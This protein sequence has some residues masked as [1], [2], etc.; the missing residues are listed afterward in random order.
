MTRL[1]IT[2]ILPLAVLVHG[3][4]SAQAPETVK[5]GSFT[6]PGVATVVSVDPG[7][8][9]CYVTLKDARGQQSTEPAAFELC[10]RQPSPLVGKRVQLQYTLSQV[11]ADA[12][13]GDPSC[14]KKQTVALITSATVLAGAA[15]PAATPAA[16]ATPPGQAS[17]CT[18]QETVVFACRAGSKMVS[19]C[20][21]K[22]AGR[23]RG[24]L[25]YRFGKPDSREPLE[26][27]LPEAP[28]P[29]ARAA[30]GENVP[31]AGGGGSW[32]RFS[33][34]D[35]AY[36]VYSGIGRWGPKGETITKQG[37]VVERGGKAIANV[38]C[39]DEPA[40]ELG[41]E[42]FEKMGVV[43]GKQDFLFP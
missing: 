30:A 17:F 23:G 6:K 4:A 7:D 22:D 32:L 38:K 20:A 18:P 37:V 36:V 19:V 14:K 8:A 24:M 39:S 16:A 43:V 40:G 31:F 34:G 25:Q 3:L 33:K 41:P 5:V 21:S 15:A 29:P 1:P 27:I 10:T 2:R 35:T 28:V 11:A 13:G 9:A 42:W 26:M 12:C